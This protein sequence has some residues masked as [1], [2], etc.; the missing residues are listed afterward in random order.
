MGTI[1]TKIVV[2]VAAE[3]IKNLLNSDRESD[4][5][6]KIIAAKTKEEI[7]EAVRDELTN[8]IIETSDMNPEIETLIEEL[9]TANSKNAIEAIVGQPKVQKG[10]IEGFVGIFTGIVGL[11]FGKKK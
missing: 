4:L 5:A 8:M 9:V 2:A 11:I 3:L 7:K 6:D 1:E 10:I